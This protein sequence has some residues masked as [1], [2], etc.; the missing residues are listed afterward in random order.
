MITNLSEEFKQITFVDKLGYIVIDHKRNAC[1]TLCHKLTKVET[2]TIDDIMC[3][4]N[5]LETGY[6]VEK[7][8]QKRRKKT[9]N[10]NVTKKIS[11]NTLQEKKDSIIS[12]HK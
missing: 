4:W 3:R 2:A 1:L 6:K 9:C 8:L 7:L 12:N 5:W 11:R 10:K